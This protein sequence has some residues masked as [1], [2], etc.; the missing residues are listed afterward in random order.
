MPK[1]TP[2][3][4][5][6]LRSIRQERG[7]SLATA[8]EA[9]GMSVSMLSKIENGQRSLTYDKLVQLATRL[10][11]DIATLF[12]EGGASSASNHVGRRSVQRREEGFVVE[13]GV[14]TYHFLAQ[15][16]V[17]KRFSPVIMDLHARQVKEFEGL[18]THEGEEFAFVLE[19]EI[20]VHTEVYAPLRLSVGDSVYFD[21]L[22]GHAYLNVGDG[23]ARI[24]T[25]ASNAEPSHDPKDL[26]VAQAKQLATS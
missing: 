14:Y 4:G 20:E 8:S 21:S 26:P 9:T 17:H 18:L 2:T 7:W 25:I 1:E 22:M 11:V 15:D 16:L 23:P 12:S 24:L 6:A 19:G 10:E 3:L 13:G 5:S